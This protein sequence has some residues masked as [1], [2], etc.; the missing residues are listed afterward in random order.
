[1]V[2]AISTLE[3]VG[4][5]ADSYQVTPSSGMALNDTFTVNFHFLSTYFQQFLVP[6]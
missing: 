4:T 1:L 5:T 6:N 3:S 2:V